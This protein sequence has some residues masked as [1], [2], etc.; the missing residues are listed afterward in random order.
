M[1]FVCSSLSFQRACVSYFSL[2]ASRLLEKRFSP[3][4]HASAAAVSLFTISKDNGRPKN[5][6]VSLPAFVTVL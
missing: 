3:V 6:G 4:R 1:A 5:A 2:Y